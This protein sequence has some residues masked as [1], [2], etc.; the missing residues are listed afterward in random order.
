[1]TLHD[2]LIAAKE[3]IDTPRKWRKDG[4]LEQGRMCIVNAIIEVVGPIESYPCEAA[5]C[6]ALGSDM[7]GRDII[8]NFNDGPR[9]THADIMAL[10]D[11]AIAAAEGRS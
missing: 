8:G 6:E 11:R 9:T 7:T 2:D 4:R 10:F 3:L 5:I 1:M